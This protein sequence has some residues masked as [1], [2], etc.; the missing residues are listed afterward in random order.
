MLRILPSRD[1]RNTVA[2]TC[3]GAANCRK[4]YTCGITPD[5]RLFGREENVDALN[6]RHPGDRTLD[7][8]GARGAVHPLHRHMQGAG[9]RWY[10][11]V[12]CHAAPLLSHV[13]RVHLPAVIDDQPGRG[14]WRY[15][16]PRP[17]TGIAQASPRLVMHR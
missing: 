2:S 13:M 14:T 16:E 7:V 1:D 5:H 4:R 11:R 10:R 3:H 6:A 17:I 15:R 9:T 8:S 12:G